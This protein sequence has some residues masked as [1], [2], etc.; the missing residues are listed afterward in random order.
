MKQ[1]ILS[2]WTEQKV[3]DFAAAPIQLQHC[4]HAN[5]LFSNE[6]LIHLIETVD[7]A[8]TR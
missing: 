2:D 7:R 5:P 3:A 1:S 4:L 6:A 8:T